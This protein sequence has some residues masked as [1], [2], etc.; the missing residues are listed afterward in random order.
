MN[1]EQ[2][3]VRDFHEHFGLPSSDRPTWPGET[4]HRLRV[5]LIEEELAELRNAGEARNLVAVA[6][7]LADLLYVVYGAAETYGIDLQAV[8]REIHRSNMSK[9]DPEIVRRP[10]GKILKGD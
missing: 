10:D 3:M 4:V 9:G 1:D 5:L 6:D 7:A 2:L 8:F